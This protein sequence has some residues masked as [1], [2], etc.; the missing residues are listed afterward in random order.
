MGPEP[1]FPK[2]VPFRP[3]ESMPLRVL[4]WHAFCH[5]YQFP[6]QVSQGW[7]AAP[8]ICCFMSFVPLGIDEF[9]G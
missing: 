8:S 7:K 9:L 2:L 6:F 5:V 1:H 4:L 3:L